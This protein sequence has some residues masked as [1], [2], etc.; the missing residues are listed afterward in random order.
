MDNPQLETMTTAELLD[1]HIAIKKE[2]AK[3]KWAEVVEKRK[4]KDKCR[5]S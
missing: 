5:I 1:L 4:E 3:R 2:L